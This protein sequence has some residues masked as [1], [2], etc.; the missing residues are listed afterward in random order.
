MHSIT[1]VTS[2]VICSAMMLSSPMAQYAHAAS[3]QTAS[4]PLTGNATRDAVLEFTGS[5]YIAHNNSQ[6]KNIKFGVGNFSAIVGPKQTHTFVDLG[7]HCFT[8][9]SPGGP[10]ANYV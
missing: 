10:W 1:K 4:V 2:A 6:S 8:S 9:F 5:C 3:P 7:G